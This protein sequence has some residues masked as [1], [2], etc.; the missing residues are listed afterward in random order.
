MSFFY[1]KNA[2]FDVEKYLVELAAADYQIDDATNERVEGYDPKSQTISQELLADIASIEGL[3]ASGRLYSR[4]ISQVLSTQAEENLESFYDEETLEN[5]EAD[6]P[7]FPYWKQGFDSA[8]QGEETIHTI[9][10]A[11][12]IILDAAAGDAYI[13]SGTYDAE[14]FATGEYVLAIGPA[15]DPKELLPTYSVGEK[16]MLENR[17]F[18]VMAVLSPL[19]PMIEGMGPAFDIPLIIPADVYTELWPDSNLRKYYFNVGMKVW[20][21]PGSCS[22]I[23]SRQRRPA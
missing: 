4:E 19:Q 16:V 15:V 14:K 17:E 18:T 11:D 9:Y 2:S 20:R 21:K 6:Y 23:I 10:G 3:E 13:L 22:V 12:G 7:A 5:F 8:V 1:A